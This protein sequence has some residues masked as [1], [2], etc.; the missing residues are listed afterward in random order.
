MNANMKL[1]KEFVLSA[2]FYINLLA[3]EQLHRT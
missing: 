2:E 1:A 3:T